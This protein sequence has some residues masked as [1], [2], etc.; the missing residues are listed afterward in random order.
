[1][2]TAYI[3]E[4]KNWMTGCQHCEAEAEDYWNERWEEVYGKNYR[5]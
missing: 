1:M 3:E 4:E 5:K 2:N